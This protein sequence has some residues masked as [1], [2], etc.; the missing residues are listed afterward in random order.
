MLE[1]AIDNEIVV[2]TKKFRGSL[3]LSAGRES[4]VALCGGCHWSEIGF[5]FCSRMLSSHVLSSSSSLLI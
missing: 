1:I 5:F 4:E 2:V 3:E